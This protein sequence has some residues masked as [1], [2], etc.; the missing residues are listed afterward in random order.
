MCSTMVEKTWLLHEVGRSYFDLGMIAEATEFGYRAM[1]AAD[2]TTE[3]V[4]QL[5]ARVLVAQSLVAG[6]QLMI[7]ILHVT[8]GALV[9]LHY[10]S[11]LFLLFSLNPGYLAQT[12]DT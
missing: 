1:E 7:E 11:W 3:G 4:W 2:Q 8:V 9:S 12:L 5:N 10:G 6:R